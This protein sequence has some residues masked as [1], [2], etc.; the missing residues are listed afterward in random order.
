MV[1]WLLLACASEHQLRDLA[2][3]PEDDAWAA[4]GDVWADLDAG[5]LPELH[6]VVAW[7][8]SGPYATYDAEPWSSWW[9]TV[10]SVFDL[11]GREVLRFAPPP[12]V[13]LSKISLEPAGPARFQTTVQAWT[14]A[15]DGTVRAD[16]RWQ[17]WQGDAVAR[18]FTPIL[19]WDPAAGGVVVEATG[20]LVPALDP[21]AL[22]TAAAFGSDPNRVW[23][24]PTQAQWCEDALGPLR[25]VSL[26][27]TAAP[28]ASWRPEALLDASEAARNGYVGLLEARTGS[29]GRDR[30]LV[31]LYRDLCVEDYAPKLTL[32]AFELPG[33]PLWSR[34]LSL[35]ETPGLGDVRFSAEGGGRALWLAHDEVGVPRSYL[36]DADG[37]VSG[38]LGDGYVGWRTGPL[39]DDWPD[40]FAAIGQHP[41]G[42]GDAIVIMHQGRRVWAVDDFA[43]GVERQRIWVQDVV[44]LPAAGG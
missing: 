17:V 29:D 34:E 4:G 25:A 1:A 42:S 23:L 43:F 31:G 33:G 24:W 8:P 22:A 12:D 2:G 40:T 15:E 6:L 18:T 5:D 36:A 44:V 11:S 16:A 28:D 26:G 39:L 21:S 37:V 3:E 30:G 38:T 20:E 41:D 7:S 13:L 10:Y 14:L 9:G 19:D 35:T 27:T 32:A